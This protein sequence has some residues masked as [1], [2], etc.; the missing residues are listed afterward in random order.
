M[1]NYFV[2][3][4]GS[5]NNNG[6]LMSPWQTPQ[7]AS[8]SARPGD[9]V[10]FRSGTYFPSSGQNQIFQIGIDGASDARIT[11]QNYQNEIVTFDASINSVRRNF[12][13]LLSNASFL[14]VRGL[15]IKSA[16]RAG[17]RAIDCQGLIVEDCAISNIRD[18]NASVGTSTPGI[19]LS[20]L[21]HNSVVQY[22]TIK[23]CTRGINVNNEGGEPISNVVVS[24]NLVQDIHYFNASNVYNNTN[25]DG[26]QFNNCVNSIVHRNIIKQ[27]GDDGIDCYASNNCI[28]EY[29]TIFNIGDGVCGII[30]AING[31]G[32]GIKVSTGGGGAHI[33]RFNICF[34][35]E[36]AGFDNS[37]VDSRAIGNSYYN[38]VA[39]GNG[40]NG[41]IAD[42]PS[43]SPHVLRNNIFWS[44]NQSNGSFTDIRVVQGASVDC[45]YNLIGDGSMNIPLHNLIGNPLFTMPPVSGIFLNHSPSNEI[46]RSLNFGY[47]H[48]FELLPISRCINSGTYVGMPYMGIRP[49]IGAYEFVGGKVTVKPLIPQQIFQIVA[50]PVST[51]KSR[52]Q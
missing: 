46:L 18:V 34:N 19:Y 51:D 20:G 43:A 25:S 23:D 14:T 30:G 16:K 5:D 40:R 47:V 32:N 45:D 50:K 9:V 2:S 12:G 28:L 21:S 15:Q 35:N 41:F 7:K 49:D 38:N 31:D 33:V 3:P 4:S 48:G 42:L 22:N 36:R 13:I 10:N 52:R 8:S 27:C 11:F 26:I 37:H 39:Y 1:P 24:C 6:S 29:N 44:N 17:I